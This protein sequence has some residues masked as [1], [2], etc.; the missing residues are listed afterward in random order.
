M[1]LSGSGRGDKAV[2]GWDWRSAHYTL[3]LMT[4]A[5]VLYMPGACCYDFK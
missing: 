2:F 4:A 1:I 3:R 5:K